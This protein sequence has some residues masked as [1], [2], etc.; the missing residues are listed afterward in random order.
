[1]SYFDQSEFEVRCEWGLAG[2]D[3]LAPASDAIIIVDVFSF[4]TSVCVAV[5]QG[6]RV[7]PYNG[8]REDLPGFAQAV[9]AILATGSRKDPHAFSLAPTSLQKIPRGQA[10]VLPSLNGSVLSLATGSV[11]T[12]AGC[13]RNAQA[14][15]KA[16]LEYGPRV[17]VIP[18]GER[19]PDGTLRP[20]LE[21]Q[22]G[23]G[24]ILHYLPGSHSPEALAAEA[25]FARFRAGLRAALGS[26]SSGKEAGEHG[27]LRD[28]DLAAD[29]NAGPVA[30]LLV[31]GAFQRMV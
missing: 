14:V 19:W 28:L 9:S 21:D 10:V 25:V 18:A 24:A 4:T 31:H 26:C 3:R 8:S 1:M 12:F 17:S 27:S 20:G 30:P 11:P 13:L 22:V 2:I 5:E 29:L 15:A 23:A 6:A 16:A 7:Y